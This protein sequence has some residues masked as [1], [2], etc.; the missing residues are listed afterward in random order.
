MTISERIEAGRRE[1]RVLTR[2]SLAA[3]RLEQ[4]ERERTW[5]LVSARAEGISIRTLA[6]AAGLSPSRVHQI[7]AVADLDALDAALGELRAAGWPAPEHPDSVEDTELGG[8][9]TIADRLSDEVSW[10]R[11]CADWLA[12]LDADSYPPA[13]NLRPSA[14]WPDR[15]LVAVD[16]ARV[17]A[18]IDR[19]AADIDELARARRVQDLTTPRC[20]PTH[21]PSAADGWPS[22]TWSSGPSAPDGGCPLPQPRSWSGPGTRG[23]PS[24]T[25]A[26]RSASGPATPTTRSGHADHWLACLPAFRKLDA[27]AVL[28]A[29]LLPAAQSGEL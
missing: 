4:A 11:Q 13:V 9:D 1:P 28:T 24:D 27:L 29:R 14:D 5:A 19:I 3:W 26:A 10:L 22:R 6:T 17:R 2:V 16:L 15:A 12:H 25:S 7:V 8:R 23:K 20:C 18:V 21:G